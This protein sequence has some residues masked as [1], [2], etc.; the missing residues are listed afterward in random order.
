MGTVLR[1][2]FT[3]RAPWSCYAC[4]PYVAEGNAHLQV[5]ALGVVGFAVGSG[6]AESKDNGLTV[7]MGRP[8]GLEPK[9]P[10]GDQVAWKND[11]VEG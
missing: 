4:V 10:P 11:L 7:K 6:R 5:V 9:P 3:D 2:I 1:F 8:P